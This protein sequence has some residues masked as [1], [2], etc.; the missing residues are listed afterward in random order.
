[1]QFEPIINY[2]SIKKRYHKYNPKSRSR[3]VTHEATCK[4]ASP[5][6]PSKAISKK[7]KEAE[8]RHKTTTTKLESH[9]IFN[10]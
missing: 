6:R 7:N 3:E 5:S 1:M 4:N 9:I 2:Y 8:K 10:A